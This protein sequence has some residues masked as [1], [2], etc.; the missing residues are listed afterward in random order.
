MFKNQ[1]KNKSNIVD[2]LARTMF[3]ALLAGGFILDYAADFT[4]FTAPIDARVDD[5]VSKLTTLEKMKARSRSTAAIARLNVR[6]YQWWVEM[7]NG[8]TTIWP[9]SMAKSCSWDQDLCY[10]MGSIQG[11]EA[12]IS[13]KYGQ[14]F[15]SPCVVNL[16]MDPRNGR[17]DENWG[18]DPYLTIYP[19]NRYARMC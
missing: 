17:N 1:A 2:F 14:Q 4:D 7:Q 18:E 15:Y 19:G 8:F 12:R 6:G 9:S 10:K 16:A 11:D 3:A 5:L 13:N